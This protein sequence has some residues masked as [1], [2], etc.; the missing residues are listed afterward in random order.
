[1]SGQRT[2]TRRK[3]LRDGLV[4]LMMMT[5]RTRGRWR[6]ILLCGEMRSPQSKVMSRM[7]VVGVR[8]D[9]SICRYGAVLQHRADIEDFEDT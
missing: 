3:A 9:W 5:T 6:V 2:M 7:V 4:W 8:V 1:M